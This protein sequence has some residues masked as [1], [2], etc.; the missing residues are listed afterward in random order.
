M[1]KYLAIAIALILGAGVLF[2]TAAGANEA[3]KTHDP[4]LPVRLCASGNDYSVD[5]YAVPGSTIVAV[6]Q[7]AD[8]PDLAE[9]NL[10]PA[11]QDERATLIVQHLGTALLPCGHAFAAC[12]TTTSGT[13]CY[14]PPAPATG[15][16][17]ADDVPVLVEVPVSTEC[18]VTAT[19]T[20]TEYF[21]CSPATA[22]AFIRGDYNVRIAYTISD[23]CTPTS[24]WVP[25]ITPEAPNPSVTPFPAFT[26]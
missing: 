21:L 10:T 24:G 19:E 11:E 15:P 2:A 9:G 4:F 8:R 20:C 23:L 12:A 25:V 13:T 1:K 17:T 22:A 14:E 18:V 16:L 7:I 3:A 5:A 26:G 6:A